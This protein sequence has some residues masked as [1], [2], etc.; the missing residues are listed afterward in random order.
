MALIKRVRGYVA[1]KIVTVAEDGDTK[2]DDY[3]LNGIYRTRAAAER[4]LRKNLGEQCLIMDIERHQQEYALP[5][6]DFWSKAKP[7]GDDVSVPFAE[8]LKK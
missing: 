8:D 5:E 7:V 1:A 4:A 6:E 3:K 2:L